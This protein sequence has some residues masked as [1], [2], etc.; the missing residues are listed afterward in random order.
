MCGLCGIVYTES[1]PFDEETLSSV[2][3]A[4]THRGPDASGSFSSTGVW[5][6]HRRLKVID[7]E[8]G[9]QPMVDTNRNIALVYNGEIYNFKELRAELEGLGETFRTQSD[10][11]VLLKCY[12]RFGI[13]CADRFRG[14]FAFAIWDGRT[15]SLLLARDGFGIKPLYYTVG[16]HWLAFASEFQ[17][18]SRLPTCERKLNPIALRYFLTYDAVPAPETLFQG[19]KKLS[20][21]ELLIWKNGDVQNDRI[22]WPQQPK[23]IRPY[24]SESI[25]QLRT[26][27]EDSVKRHLISDV[28]VGVF[29]SG[30]LDSSYIAAVASRHVKQLKTFSISFSETSFDESS[31]A[32]DVACH[33]GSNHTD[34]PLTPDV[35]KELLLRCPDFIDEPLADP[36]VLAMY[37]LSQEARRHVTVAL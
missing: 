10:T 22:S 23:E 27:L 14:M 26:V 32:N 28:P 36:A 20:A 13:R 35:A 12:A 19:V 11:E 21:G 6:G 9:N 33:I 31:F 25:S 3:R 24:N 17:A 5:F 4:L 34:I 15:N 1:L 37:L 16:P 2:Q 29:L 18:L 30:G 8:S 7:L